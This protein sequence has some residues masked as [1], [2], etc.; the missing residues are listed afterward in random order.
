MYFSLSWQENVSRHL[1]ISHQYRWVSLWKQLQAQSM[2][3]P[4]LWCTDDVWFGSK[5]I[6]PSFTISH[7]PSLLFSMYCAAN[8][9]LLVLQY[10]K[11]LEGTV[12]V[13]ADLRDKNLNLMHKQGLLKRTKPTESWRIIEEWLELLL[14]SEVSHRLLLSKWQC[15][16]S[17]KLHW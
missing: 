8:P 5:Q 7:F 9:N 17:Y 3:L 6:Y 4:P 13:T 14:C 10:Q 15:Q 16:Y 2:T 11:R 12:C 1:W